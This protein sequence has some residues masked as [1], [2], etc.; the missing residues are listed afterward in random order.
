MRKNLKVANS[1]PELEVNKT[2]QSARVSTSPLKGSSLSH[3]NVDSKNILGNKMQ[4]AVS[5]QGDLVC[6]GEQVTN[7][8]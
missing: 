2:K 4:S 5:L 1:K 8:D 7:E 3:R 6:F